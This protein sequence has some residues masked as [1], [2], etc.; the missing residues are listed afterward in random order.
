R[1]DLENSGI[2]HVFRRASESQ[3][4]LRGRSTQHAP[5]SFERKLSLPSIPDIVKMRANGS[6]PLSPATPTSLQQPMPK[7]LR[8]ILE[9]SVG[10][11]APAY[12]SEAGQSADSAYNSGNGSSINEGSSSNGRPSDNEEY[13]IANI[14][15]FLVSSQL[16]VMV[17]HYEDSPSE[18]LLTTQEPQQ[19]MPDKARSVSQPPVARCDCAAS[20]PII[21]DSER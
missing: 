7:R 15:L 13:L 12:S 11:F 18:G 21:A 10:T 19:P 14:G 5:E 6:Q 9:D 8:T 1:F 16:F 4:L 3:I 17:C 2:Q 20:T